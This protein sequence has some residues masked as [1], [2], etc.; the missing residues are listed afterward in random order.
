[1]LLELKNIVKS[2]KLWEENFVVL[3]DVN[4]EVKEW[5]FLAIMGPSGSG[6]STLMN[7]IWMLDSPNSWEYH[8]QWK[9]I[10]KLS[11]WKQ[12][13]IRREKIGFVF[14]NYSLIPRIS[15]IEQV[16]LPLIYQWVAQKEATEKAKIALEKVG[17]ADKIKSMPNE[18][19]WWQ[20]QRVAIARAIVISPSIILAD[21]PTWALDTKT[22]SDIMDIFAEL[23][24]EWKT[25]LVITH[26]QE[27]AE[28]TKKTISIR[29]WKI[30]E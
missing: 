29:D 8:M 9:R 4:L 24:N 5:D 19:S 16:K 27:V 7:I 13:L 10:D 22:W 28:K 23:N 17:L 12:S 3:D 2:Y 25:I 21:E 26:E 6:K 14:Q 30:I 11:D 1:M 15:V 18:L 20:K